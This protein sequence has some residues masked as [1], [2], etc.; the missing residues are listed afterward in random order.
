MWETTTLYI[1]LL[2]IGFEVSVWLLLFVLALTGAG[3]LKEL[4]TSLAGGG[5]GLLVLA[6]ALALAYLLGIVCDKIA[7]F[8]LGAQCGPLKHWLE[9][10]KPKRDDEDSPWIYARVMIREKR[11]VS[12]ILYAN[13]KVRILRSSVINVLLIAIAGAT[14]LFSQGDGWWWLALVAGLDLWLLS[15]FA[16][17]YTLKIY[18]L[19]LLRFNTYLLE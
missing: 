14:Y 9:G 1:E 10:I 19:R 8:F 13:S 18:R 6:L 2:I 3:W 4:L 11:A 5:A 16:Y 15:C 12:D 7:R 17:V